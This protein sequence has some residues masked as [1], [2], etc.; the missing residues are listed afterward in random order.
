MPLLSV[1]TLLV[2]RIIEETVQ[3]NMFRL[4]IKF[5]KGIMIIARICRSHFLVVLTHLLA[6][7]DTAGAQTDLKIGQNL[8][9]FFNYFFSFSFFWGGGVVTYHSRPVDIQKRHTI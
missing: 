7:K 6:A 1:T 9:F 2:R 4:F 5:S 3:T 8:I